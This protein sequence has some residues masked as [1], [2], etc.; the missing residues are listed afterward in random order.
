[1][2]IFPTGGCQWLTSCPSCFYPRKEPLY[3]YIE[4]YQDLIPGPSSSW[5]CCCTAHVTVSPNR[6][7]I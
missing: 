5:N 3:L 4:G 1:M 2:R 7:T 6:E